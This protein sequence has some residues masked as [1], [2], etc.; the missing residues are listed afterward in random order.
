[1]PATRSGGG[2]RRRRRRR[3]GRRGGLQ[4]RRAASSESIAVVFNVS[5]NFHPA[6]LRSNY[7]R[8]FLAL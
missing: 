4:G 6:G 8:I 2:G 7:L 5:I 1:M 3:R